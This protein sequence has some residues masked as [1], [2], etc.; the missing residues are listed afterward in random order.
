MAVIA[1]SRGSFSGGINVAECVSE[2][3][4]YRCLCRE[5]MVGTAAKRYGLQVDKLSKAIDDVP[6]IWDPLRMER[7]HYLTCLRACLVRQISS[8]NVVYHGY[9]G[10][11]LL[12]GVPNILR[13]RI[14]ANMEFR[15][16]SVMEQNHLSREKAIDYIKREDEK[17]AK[18]TKFLYDVDWSDPTWYDLVINIDTLDISDACEII[19]SIVKL[20]KFKTTSETEKTMTNLILATEVQAILE[21]HEDIIYS[22]VNVEADGSTVILS[23]LLETADKA[24]KIVKVV[25]AV[26]GVSDVQSRIRIRKVF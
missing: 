19:T 9:V 10:H 15:V 21:T 23:G 14:V 17:R 6:G 8:D 11:F 16:K 13:V 26:P 20:D 3:L 22:G 24:D 7:H 1:I 5:D 25:K 4:G 18:W 2:K 12:R